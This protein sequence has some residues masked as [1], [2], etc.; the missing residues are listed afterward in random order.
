MA[1]DGVE[2]WADVASEV[3]GHR[4]AVA[5]SD[6]DQD[7]LRARPIAHSWRRDRVCRQVMDS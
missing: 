6:F 4:N 5:E 1:G 7:V 2:P 3:V